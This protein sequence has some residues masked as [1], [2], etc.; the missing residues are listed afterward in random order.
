MV[1][2]AAGST[3]A[4]L[5]AKAGHHVEVFERQ[6]FPRHHIGESTSPACMPI[7]DLVDA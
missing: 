6:H 3:M 4:G 5:L 2:G 7:L 1:G